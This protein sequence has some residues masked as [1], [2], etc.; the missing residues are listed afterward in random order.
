MTTGGGV[1][2]GAI[3]IEATGG[4]SQITNTGAIRSGGAAATFGISYSATGSLTI[5][6]AGR[7][8]AGSGTAISSTTGALDLTNSG[9]IHGSTAITCGH[10][11]DVI[12][13][14]GQIQGNVFLGSGVNVFDTIGGTF[15][16]T[17]IGDGSDTYR[18]DT[19]IQIA[20]TLGV[21]RI[22]ASFDITLAS[23]SGIENLLLLTGATAGT[24]NNLGNQIEGNERDNVLSGIAG[25]DVLY[26][27]GGNDM[28]DGG[29]DTDTLNGGLG[30]DRLL[31][32]AGNDS[33]NGDDGEDRIQGGIG[34]TSSAAA[35][36]TI[37]SSGALGAIASP[38]ARAPTPSSF[39][40]MLKA[41]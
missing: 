38:V 2:D 17:V 34:G 15:T 24:G 20:D 37:R 14:H 16:G 35:T 29:L 28:L 10:V 27:N 7:I 23:Y 40:P 26:G 4:N 9:I 25:I 1:G 30:D 13:N 18:L 8:E 5:Q 21:D 11:S 41:G 22:E 3:V 6:N 31:G 36:V 33:V 12:L 32:R 19:N 39:S